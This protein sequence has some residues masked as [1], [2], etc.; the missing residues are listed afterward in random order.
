MAKIYIIGGG[1]VSCHLAKAFGIRHNVY[2]LNSRGLDDVPMD[3]DL[4]VVAVTDSAIKQVAGELPAVGGIVVHTSGSVTMEAI[5]AT[6]TK[7]GVLYPLQ[8]FSKDV[9]LDY[10]TISFF[11][12]A[13]SQDVEREIMGFVS[14]ITNKIYHADS[15]LRKRIHLSGVISCNFVNHLF[16][17]SDILL[18]DVGLTVDILRPLIDETVRKISHT[19]PAD[20]QTGP[21]SRQDI[22]ILEEHLRIL[23]KYP[24]I[25]DLYRLLSESIIKLR[26][27]NL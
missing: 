24:D 17:L 9:P 21:A 25:K 19:K 4:Y 18:S 26:Y 2:I 23:D 1:N 3:G 22:K 10:S 11:I 6:H 20:A 8:T 16:A 13:N 5:P 27:G 15:E 14:D 7:R 12:E